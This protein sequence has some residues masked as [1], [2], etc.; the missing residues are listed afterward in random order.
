MASGLDSARE[1]LQWRL[2]Y[3][4]NISD[5]GLRDFAECSY[6]PTRCTISSLRTEEAKN[7]AVFN[8]QIEWPH[9]HLRALAPE[10][11]AVGFFEAENFYRC[12]GNRAAKENY[13]E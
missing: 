3:A 13:I 4:G 9:R 8:G 6:Q 12:H 7:L 11:N 1:Q 10:A 5:I 2:N